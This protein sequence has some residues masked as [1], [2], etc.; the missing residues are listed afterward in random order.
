MVGWLDG[1]QNDIC[2]KKYYIFFYSLG[3]AVKF[4]LWLMYGLSDH[5]TYVK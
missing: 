2:L 1:V 3:C 4:V 5:I